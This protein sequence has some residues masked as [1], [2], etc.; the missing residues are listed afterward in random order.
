MMNTDFTARCIAGKAIEDI[1]GK[2][3]TLTAEQ[4]AAVNSGITSADVEQIE[5][6]KNNILLNWGGAKNLTTITGGTTE[7][8]SRYII[9]NQ[10][11]TLTAGEYVISFKTS[12]TTGANAVSLYNNNNQPI[13]TATIINGTGT[14]YGNI[15]I[16]EE[17][18]IIFV[19]ATV[20]ETIT[21]FMI[22]T[23]TDW[24]KSP[25]YAPYAM[26][27]VDLTAAIKALQAQLANQ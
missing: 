24:E 17:S 14:V 8:A 7:V 11:L 6:N 2:Q 26:S 15:S 3:D 13:G 5:T 12:A 1:A 21:E 18:A 23:K 22:C 10:P 20:P 9:N 25:V 16:A 4:L 19:F 27:N